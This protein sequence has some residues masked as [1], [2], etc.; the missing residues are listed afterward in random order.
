MPRKTLR[1]I[2]QS[3][4]QGSNDDGRPVNSF[5]SAKTLT[6]GGGRASSKDDDADGSMY[7]NDEDGSLNNSS[8]AAKTRR[9]REGEVNSESG[10]HGKSKKLREAA[11]TGE[12]LSD[13]AVPSRLGN[14]V[15]SAKTRTNGGGSATVDAEDED[16]HSDVSSKMGTEEQGKAEDAEERRVMEILEQLQNLPREQVIHTLERV[17]RE[18]RTSPRVNPKAWLIP[19]LPSTDLRRRG[20][21]ERIFQ[22]LAVDLIN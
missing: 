12:D 8:V 18:S 13:S 10:G 16:S 11:P 2:S 14:S 15:E 19:K 1:E 5:A 4:G 21:L 22:L 9:K 3:S 20:R 6:N 17:M 7:Q